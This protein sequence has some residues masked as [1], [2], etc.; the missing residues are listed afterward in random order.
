MSR[1]L[2]RFTRNPLT[3]VALLVVLG[4]IVSALFAPRLA[5]HQPN[6]QD[7]RAVLQ[8][9][10]KEHYLGT[11]EIGR[12]IYSRV[13]F[14][15]RISVTVGV[16]SVA[17]GG[18]I[19]ISVGLLAGFYGGLLDS[20]LMRFIDVLLAFPGILLAILL[21]TALGAGL[22]PVVIAV[23]AY[24]VPTFAR[25]M[26]GSVLG[27]RSR[28]FVE[29]ARA[30]GARSHRLIVKHVFLNAFSPVLVYAT[31]LMGGAILTAAALSFLGVGVAPPTPEWGAMISTARSYMRQAP[32]VIL[33][34]GIA[35]FLTVLAFNVLGDALRDALDP[36]N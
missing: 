23:A 8:P 20:V 9:P 3:I 24:S 21:A 4:L 19:G 32:H 18:L 10:S 31:L 13:I 7:F 30:A 26:R 27:V 17:L 12:D 11:D 33:G 5:T 1:S 36:K 22:G 35:I 6:R 14:G 16:L 29:A 25:V 15:A 28:E 34:P 2:K